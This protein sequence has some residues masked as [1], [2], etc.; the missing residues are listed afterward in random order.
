MSRGRA[1]GERVAVALGSN[2]GF[3][4][5][6][7]GEA[8]RWLGETLDGIVPSGVYE[9]EPREGAKGRP[10]LNMCVRGS[11]DLPA[12]RL[13]RALLDRERFQGRVRRER[14]AGA[15]TLDLDLLLYGDGV[16]D[17]EE[18]RVP[19][20]RMTHRA[21]VLFPLAE[22]AGEWRHPTAGRSVGE[23]AAGVDRAGVRRIG[24]AA[25]VLGLSETI[26]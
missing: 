12:V 1:P 19:H 13:L 15:R 18:L 21:F 4:T 20:P 17:R 8:V 5:R 10:F 22:I 7:L 9:S 6:E 16:I 25:E 11:T 23:L 3:R 14:G 26:G 24:D 2:R